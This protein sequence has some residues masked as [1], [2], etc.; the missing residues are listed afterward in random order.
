MELTLPGVDKKSLLPE[1][2]KNLSVN[3]YMVLKIRVMC[4]SVIKIIFHL[5]RRNR[6]QGI[7][8]PA[9]KI[10]WRS[11]KSECHDIHYV[12]SV[13]CHESRFPDVF[14]FNP[15]LVVTNLEIELRED[16]STMHS[17][18]HFVNARERIAVL[19]SDV[20]KP[21][22]IDYRSS[23]AVLLPNEEKGGRSKRIGRCP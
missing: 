21:P 17:F 11:C 13:G 10:G 9:L 6:L 15:E 12:G 22:I 7:R 5:L 3:L 23:G 2:L 19:D 14:W 16:L 4:A 8:H 1:T 20:I 18:Q